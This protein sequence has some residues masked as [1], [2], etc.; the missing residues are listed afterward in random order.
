MDFTCTGMVSQ[1]D[2]FP[3]KVEKIY[4]SICGCC[5]YWVCLL[6]TVLG[7]KDGVF[8]VRES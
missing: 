5:R 7:S 3:Y 4:F 6:L 1:T 2:F 8:K